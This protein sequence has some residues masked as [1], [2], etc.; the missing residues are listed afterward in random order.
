MLMI[1]EHRN[2][3]TLKLHRCVHMHVHPYLDM[4]VNIRYFDEGMSNTFLLFRKLL[5]HHFQCSPQKHIE[6][7]RT[8]QTLFLQLRNLRI[9]SIHARIHC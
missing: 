9:F 7:S 2:I 5:N 8:P 1:K 3:N 6:N 4:H